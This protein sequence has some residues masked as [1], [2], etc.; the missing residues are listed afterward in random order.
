L[1]P[2]AVVWARGKAS[3][4]SCP[5]SYIAPESIAL[6]EEYHAWKLFGTTDFNRLPA[7]LVQAI[8]VLEN[9]LRMERNDAEK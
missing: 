3:T 5:I 6:L 1:T 4:P 2:A 8:I 7:R 9:E